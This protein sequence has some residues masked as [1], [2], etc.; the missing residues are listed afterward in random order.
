[1][2]VEGEDD[3]FGGEQ[4]LEKEIVGARGASGCREDGAGCV[5]GPGGLIAGLGGVDGRFAWDGA[6]VGVCEAVVWLGSGMG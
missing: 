4:V 2:L 6:A 5:A 3:P 1:L